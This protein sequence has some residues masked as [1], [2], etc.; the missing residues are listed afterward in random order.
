[1]RSKIQVN[2][3]IDLVCDYKTY[4][5]DCSLR[6]GNCSNG[7][8]CHHVNGSCRHGCNAGVSGD[9][10]KDGKYIFFYFW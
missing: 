9:Q 6:C 3:I 10:C 7:E 2:E 8:T 4:G 5:Q 1:M